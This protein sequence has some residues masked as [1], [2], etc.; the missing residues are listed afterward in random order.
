MSIKEALERGPMDRERYVLSFNQVRE[1][2]EKEVLE[3][4]RELLK[5]AGIPTLL[6]ELA[7][8]IKQGFSDIR[9]EEEILNRD[10]TVLTR[11]E[12]NFRNLPE[13]LPFRS[14]DYE[15]N[16]IHVYARPLTKDFLIE[17]QESEQII[18]QQWRFGD[19]KDVEDAIVRAY[20]Q[21]MRMTGPPGLIV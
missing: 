17:G 9:V 12:W 16:A 19:P 3:K 18:E 21:P 14:G 4:G 13:E 11:L 5:G 2:Y 10:G 6:H 15:Y 20:L 1:G 8:I 7:E